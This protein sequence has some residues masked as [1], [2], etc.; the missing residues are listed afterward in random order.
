MEKLLKMTTLAVS[1]FFAVVAPS[2]AADNPYGAPPWTIG[3]S[4]DTMDHPWRAF[5]VTS[6]EAQ[7][8][9][10]PELIKE[11]IYTDAKGT[12]EKQIADIEDLIARGVDLIMMSPREA[13][14][15]VPAVEAIKK[16]GIP[17]VVLDREIVGEDYNVFIGGNNLSLAEGL[18]KHVL[19]SVGEKFSY[20]EL[21]G[22]PGATPTIQ[23]QQGFAAQLEG[24]ADIKLLDAR[25]ANYDLAPAIPIVEDWLTR[26][27]DQ[28][29]VIY[30][31]ND[32]MILGAI[33]VLKEAGYKPG[34]VYLIGVDGQREA[35]QAI[36]DGWLQA[37]SIYATGGAIGL[38]MA[39]RVLKG[40]P[41]PKRIT[42]ETPIV[43]K[44]NVDEFYN[45]DLQYVR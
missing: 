9:K 6:A 31:H 36:K 8:K 17:L 23:R 25:P 15:L 24:K 18:G 2:T 43:T 29:Q 14:A 13:Q 37:T 21:E 45:A 40:E 39:V 22:I 16:A 27:R 10:Y 30:A 41:V 38:D 26:Y 20:L 35:F 3:F 32:P 7:A 34:D 4:Q 1:A 28:F 5:M 12:N 11:F 42:T 44:D 33:N 19:G